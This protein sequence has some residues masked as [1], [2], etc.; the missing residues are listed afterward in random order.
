MNPC[1]KNKKY[2]ASLALNALDAP[3]SL[4]LLE[5][6][7]QC[8][9]C[10]QYWEEMSSTSEAL[11]TGKPAADV[12]I[13]ERFYR[14][15]EKRIK[16]ARSYS[17][18]EHLGLWGGR[19]LWNWRVVLPIGALLFVLCM[20]VIRLKHDPHRSLAERRSSHPIDAQTLDLPPTIASYKSVAS[21]SLEQFSELLNRQGDKPLPPA[22]IYTASGG[23]LAKSSL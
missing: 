19:V 7:G 17:G 12:E 3:R 22:P 15:V 20:T 18:R 10:R 4:E 21:Q 23:V 8:A 6:L 9:P 11:K 13:S 5:H 2:I 16:T 1:S 14:R